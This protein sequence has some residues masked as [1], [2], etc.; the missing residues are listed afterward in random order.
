MKERSFT[1]FVPVAMVAAGVLLFGAAAW[2]HRNSLLFHKSPLQYG[3]QVET[4]TLD[5]GSRR[6]TLGSGRWD[7]ILIDRFDTGLQLGSYLQFLLDSGR[8]ARS[9]VNPV[10]LVGDD[11][12]DPIHGERRGQLRIP[13]LSI[14]SH[15]SE[16]IRRGFRFEDK[17]VVFID[18]T[19]RVAFA[20]TFAKPNDLRQLFEKFIPR[21]PS[22]VELRSKPLA[23]G[24]A[25]PAMS[26]TPLRA[27]PAPSQ[28]GGPATWVIFG[29]KCGSCVLSSYTLL[30]S[31]LEADLLR[32]VDASD[33]PVSLVFSS[34]IPPTELRARLEQLGVKSPAFIAGGPMRGI[35]SDFTE[36]PL[37][38]SDVVVITTNAQNEVVR[39]DPF[40]AY[41]RR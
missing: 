10:V 5:D 22:V 40:E 38:D 7:V 34:L 29:G 1:K 16:L 23:P 26:L 17:R 25:M 6:V 8:Y 18:P 30:Y 24:D 3:Q 11:V 33:A 15:E 14:K 13:L 32:H 4:A 19:R 21:A 9:A 37:S 12:R 35:E 27:K 31:S 36:T 28:A 41:L 2:K 39:I 20:A